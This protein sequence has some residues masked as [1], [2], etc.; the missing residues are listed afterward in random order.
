M[1]ATTTTT[2][3]SAKPSCE[4]IPTTAKIK[5]GDIKLPAKGIF[6][7]ESH[8]VTKEEF[9]GTYPKNVTQGIDQH[10]ERTK[11]YLESLGLS[12]KYQERWDKE[13]TPSEGGH[14][15][16]G[17]RGMNRPTVEQETWQMNQYYRAGHLPPAGEKWLACFSGKCLVLANGFEVGPGTPKDALG[18]FTVESHSYLGTVSRKSLITL[19]GK[20]KDQSVPY[21]PIQ[22]EN[23]L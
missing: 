15:G 17:A 19:H 2:V 5:R 18:G 10:L 9:A 12:A 4:V 6:V 1:V 14:I 8:Y 3:P 13:W 11:K 16:Q 22:C 21:G 20:L 23:S 7:K